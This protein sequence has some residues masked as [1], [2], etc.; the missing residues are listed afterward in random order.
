PNV[1]WNVE[2]PD[3]FAILEF[4]DLI[5]DGPIRGWDMHDREQRKGVYEQ[6]IRGGSPDEMIRWIDGPLLVDVWG[7]LDLPSPV[8]EAWKWPVVIARGATKQDAVRLYA[9]GGEPYTAS[10][11]IRGHEQLPKE[12]SRPREPRV[13]FV[14]T[15]FD[16]RPPKP[17][18]DGGG[19]E[20]ADSVAKIVDRLVAQLPTSRHLSSPATWNSGV[21]FARRW[22]AMDNGHRSVLLAPSGPGCVVGVTV[23]PYG[24]RGEVA[25]QLFELADASSA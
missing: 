14:R 1:L 8:R 21:A 5:N 23:E 7:E 9:R 6:L 22:E 17:E 19:V 12:P 13:R 2:T 3:C 10:A 4:P 18:A 15:R 25:E 11:W 16:P 20:V 24:D